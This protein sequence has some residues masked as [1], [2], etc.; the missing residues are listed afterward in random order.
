[1]KLVSFTVCPYVQRAVF[2]L[3]EKGARYDVQYIDLDRK[4]EWFLALSPRGKVPIL[5]LDDGVVLFESQAICEFLDETLGEPLASRDPSRRARE[6]AWFAF[7]GEDLFVP[8]YQLEVATTAEA[9]ET[10]RQALTK[11]LT[12]LEREMEG[13]T[14]LSG[15]GSA[16]GLADVAMLPAFT[17]IAHHAERDGLDV[18]ADLPAVGAWSARLLARPAAARS[19]PATWER[20][21]RAMMARHGSVLAG[22]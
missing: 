16:F 11:A 6:R 21:L 4:P 18:L 15:D 22:C 14:W 3:E 17:R 7:S 10:R 20:D 2:A 12:R 9:V 1:M 13:R 8:L 5:V 19:I